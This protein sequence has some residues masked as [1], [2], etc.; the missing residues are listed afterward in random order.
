M[1]N[2]EETSSSANYRTLMHDTANCSNYKILILMYH[3]LVTGRPSDIYKRNIADFENDLKYIQSKHYEVISFDDLIKLQTG[4]KKLHSNAVIISFDDGYASDYNLAY[5]KLKIHEMPATFFIVTEWVG[6]SNRIS[7]ADAY[8]MSQYSNEKGSK[9]FSIESHTSSHP[10]LAKDSIQFA[11]HTA[12]QAS[13]DDEFYDS[14]TWIQ[15]STGQNSM[16]MALPYG[17]GANNAQIITTAK[18]FGY[19]GIRT[20]IYGSFTLK[21]MNLNALPSLPILSTTQISDM[22]LYLN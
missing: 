15:S 8:T 9:L 6:D 11:N 18:K 7:W 16:W 2:P 13:L 5:P 22:D 4:T 20:S 19:T 1:L 3:E 10:F 12:Y 14:K 21:S 17:D